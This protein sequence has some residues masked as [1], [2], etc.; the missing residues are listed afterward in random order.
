MVLVDG[1]RTLRVT[2]KDHAFAVDKGAT[3]ARAIVEGMVVEK[4]NDPAEAAH[5]A[6][7]SNHPEKAPEATAGAKKFELVATGVEI[8][9]G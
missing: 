8:I 3:G 4:A 2:V 9:K 7:E 5:F 6:S 1:G